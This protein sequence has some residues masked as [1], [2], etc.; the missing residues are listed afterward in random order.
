M[1]AEASAHMLANHTRDRIVVTQRRP[2]EKAPIKGP[3]TRPP[4][5]LHSLLFDRY[6]DAV[7]VT[8]ESGRIVEANLAATS[9]LGYPRAELLALG[10]SD[11]S[12]SERS[13]AEL[14]RWGMEGYWRDEI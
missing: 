6:A 8:D 11:I 14:T 10:A 1:R 2:G 12:T 7:L 5:S 9:L 3:D 4:A 13:E